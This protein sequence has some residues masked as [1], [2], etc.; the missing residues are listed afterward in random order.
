MNDLESTQRKCPICKKDFH[1]IWCDLWAYK[2]Q[3]YGGGGYKYYCSW[4]C[5]REDERRHEKQKRPIPLAEANRVP[6]VRRE[7]MESR[8]LLKIVLDIIDKRGPGAG[9]EYLESLGYSQW[10]KWYNLKKWAEQ[11]DPEM[12]KRMPEKLS[13]KRRKEERDAR[14]AGDDLRRDGTG[15]DEE[16]AEAGAHAG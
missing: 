13:D 8:V 16:E 4:H 1:V 6:G 3:K 10:K 11:H 9:A 14:A 15:E 5:M 12:L 2:T 7:P